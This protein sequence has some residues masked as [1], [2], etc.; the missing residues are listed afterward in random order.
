MARRALAH[1]S[2]GPRCEGLEPRLLLSTLSVANLVLPEGNA[3]SKDFNFAV[4][5]SA[6][7]GQDVTVYYRTL[8]GTATA[9]EDYAAVTDVLITIPA[10][11]TQS[12]ATVAVAGD[13]T[14]E[15][16][17][18]FTVELFDASGATI[19]KDRATGAI[20]NDDTASGRLD[21]WGDD[22]YGQLSSAPA[23]SDF[24]AVGGPISPTRT[25]IAD[26]IADF[27]DQNLRPAES[28]Q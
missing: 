25:E 28:A 21:V 24:V 11:Q 27:F 4:S 2:D 12:A 26:R 10:G 20:L 22:S 14:C 19:E 8:S 16:F 17:E 3:G 18:T 9:G 5:L 13:T 23:G 1:P 15:F 6:P 7:A